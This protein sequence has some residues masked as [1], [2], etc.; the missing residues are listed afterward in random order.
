[1][2]KN[3]RK[4]MTKKEYK[5]F[6]KA[7]IALTN[8]FIARGAKK[9]DF[10]FEGSTFTFESDYAPSEEEIQSEELQTIMK[11]LFASLVAA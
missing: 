3:K 7:T 11:N 2:S 9:I 8:Y 6:E 1:M 5:R 4:Y 10:N